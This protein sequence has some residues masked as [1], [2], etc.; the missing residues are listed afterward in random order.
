MIDLLDHAAFDPRTIAETVQ[1][2]SQS[3]E[4]SFRLG[5]DPRLGAQS[6]YQSLSES[7]IR[8]HTEKLLPPERQRILNEFTAAGPLEPFLHDDSV[9]EIMISSRQ[10]I[11]VETSSKLFQ[12]GDFFYA[13]LT[14]ANFIHRVC[15]E[16][17][18][19]TTYTMPFANGFWRGFR[20]HLASPP[21]AQTHTLTLR[22][23]RA[24][25]FSLNDLAEKNW[26]QPAELT[27]LKDIVGQKKNCIVVGNTGSGKTTLLNALVHEAR[28]D[29]CVVIEDTPEILT[30]N[31]LSVKLL[32]RFDSQGVLPDITQT[33]LVKQSLR[34]RPDRLIIGEVRGAE[35]KDLLMAL[36]TGHRGS[37]TSLHAHTPSEALLRLEMLIQMGAPQWSLDAIRRLIQLTVDAVIV[38]RR[39]NS[40]WHLEGIY[41]I[42]SQEKFGFL[43]E[44]IETSA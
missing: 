34:M 9:V 38:T 39:E 16:A 42:S 44:R 32:T 13:D 10:V 17:Q 8:H 24:H 20:V 41:K 11:W 36:A 30:A 23:I 14:Y 26:C 7:S 12:L 27:Q 25:A 31:S 29:R 18:M 6:A 33:D 43:I 28:A 5:T 37:M 4:N 2:I 15:E 19:Q 35:A 40:K 3:F 21:V 1:N 22:K